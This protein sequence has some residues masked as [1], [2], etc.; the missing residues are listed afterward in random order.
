MVTRAGSAGTTAPPPRSFM[1]RR[2]ESKPVARKRRWRVVLRDGYLDDVAHAPRHGAK[3]VVCA[4][5]NAAPH[6]GVVEPEPKRRALLDPGA[7]QPRQRVSR[8]TFPARQVDRSRLPRAEHAPQLRAYQRQHSGCPST[9]REMA[10]TSQKSTMWLGPCPTRPLLCTARSADT[11]PGTA[12][13][14]GCRQGL[15]RTRGALRH[16]RRALYIASL[17]AD[18]RLAAASQARRARSHRGRRSR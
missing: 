12:C 1:H 16:R 8:A 2:A 13:W 4:V 3:G 7:H 15:G 17:P 10:K 5:E 9:L 18:S 6:A 14:I 11:A